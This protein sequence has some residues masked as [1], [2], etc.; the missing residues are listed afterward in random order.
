MTNEMIISKDVYDEW[1][2]QPIL[3]DEDEWN[4]KYQTYGDMWI[5]EGYEIEQG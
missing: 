4:G 2:G 3:S 5:G 1:K